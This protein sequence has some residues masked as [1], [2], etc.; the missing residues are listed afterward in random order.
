MASLQEVKGR[1]KSIDSTKQ[2]TN[3]MNLVATAKL[4]RSRE[5]VVKTRPFFNTVQETIHSIISHTNGVSHPFIK[6]NKVDNATFIVI[7]SD[8]GLCGGYNANVCKLALESTKQKEHA[9]I[10]TVGKKAREYFKARDI[11][12]SEEIIGVSESPTYI[13]ADGIARNIIEQYKKGKTGEVYLVYTVFE[14]VVAQVPKVVQL[15]PLEP[16]K[17]G[18][19]SKGQGA[20]MNYDPSPEAVLEYV[21]P[22]YI[23]SVIYG[24]LVESAASEQGARMTAMSS[25]TDN[26]EEMLEDL[27]IEYN[28][29]RQAAITQELS[30]IVGGAEALQ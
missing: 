27:S 19:E 21:I 5:N 16:E 15:L 28:R 13:H 20:L 24:A 6:S 11:E 12:I 17:F 25:A 26:A 1:M 4:T 23:T 8:M 2:I 18:L 10:I 29:A 7:A 22:K 9:D 30:E 14:S 3:A